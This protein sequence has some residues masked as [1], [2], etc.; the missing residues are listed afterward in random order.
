MLTVKIW[1]FV[2]VFFIEE[3][4]CLLRT[5][6]SILIPRRN[7]RRTIQLLDC[8]EQF[9]DHCIKRPLEFFGQFL[10]SNR[11]ASKSQFYSADKISEK[12]YSESIVHPP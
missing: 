1:F 4:R 8:I 3:I 12:H 6:R 5:I 9:I 10:I 11:F 7:I 2:R